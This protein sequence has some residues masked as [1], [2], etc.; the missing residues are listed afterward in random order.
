MQM[1]KYDLGGKEVEGVV[2]EDAWLE[3][4]V[5]PQRI[6]DAIVAYRAHQRQWSANTQTRSEVNHS[7]K[8]PHPQ[9]G[10]G[11]ARQGYLGSPQFRG[12]GRVHAPR[13][14]FAQRLKVN[15]K[16]KQSV[17][18]HLLVERILENRLYVLQYEALGQ[19]K[20]KR[21]VD[22]LKR[23]EMQKK[24][25]LFLWEM[26]SEGMTSMQERETWIRSMRNIPDVRFQFFAQVNAYEL[27]LPYA[28]F[29]LEPA[30]EELKCTLKGGGHA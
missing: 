24:R 19:P 27:L 7:G 12:G 2:L 22:F 13:P 11:K 16:E 8:K 5:Q 14:K 28:I 15:R 10:T 6:K 25:I 29:V 4:K 9:K 30:L 17:I 21:I 1:K 18:R 3:S 23:V 20:T 26:A